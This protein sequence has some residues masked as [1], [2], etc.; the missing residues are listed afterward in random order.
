MLL[1]GLRGV[2]F[3]GV[4]EFFYFLK[5]SLNAKRQLTVLNQILYMGLSSRLAR[6]IIIKKNFILHLKYILKVIKCLKIK[7]NG[8]RLKLSV[9]LSF[10]PTKETSRFYFKSA[11]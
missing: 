8:Q 11:R 9:G 7:K 10:N 2:I 5:V 3:D 4:M 6:V 1:L